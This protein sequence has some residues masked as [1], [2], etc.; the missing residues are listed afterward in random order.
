MGC[1]TCCPEPPCPAPVLECDSIS[2]SK[3]KPALCGEI[4]FSDWK[5]YSKVTWTYPAG[6]TRQTTYA[7]DSSGSCVGTEVY[8]GT[9]ITTEVSTCHV[10]YPNGYSCDYSLTV[11]TTDVYSSDGSI[12]R[13]FSG[14]GESSRRFPDYS[15]TGGGPGEDC[16]AT[17]TVSTGE[18]GGE[19]IVW[20]GT[21]TVHYPDPIGDATVDTNYSCCRCSESTTYT[22][23]NNI[24]VL[25]YSDEAIPETTAALTSRTVAA[26]P[27]YPETWSG[28]CHS[29]RN[30][31]TDETSYNIVR[32]KWRVKH[33]PT[34][35][36]YLK[37]WLQTR[38]VPEDGGDPIITPIPPY[39]WEQTGNPCFPDTSY[40]PGAAENLIRSD[41]SEEL[42][43]SDD[44]T[45]YVEIVKY[46]CLASYTPPDDGSANGLPPA[47]TE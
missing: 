37:V 7:L 36:C 17:A 16:S 42:E 9:D 39:V 35:T 28:Y 32:T 34:G 3:S 38:F 5:T 33:S 29:Y 47:P 14:S 25:T 1:D 45:T 11:V 40:G 4:N 10:D 12:T 44:G 8:S 18:D 27:A 41:I 23:A 6:H 43:P 21:D 46:S 20:A 15:S 22:P 19:V 24:P 2:A 26:L 31:S 30:L 13:T